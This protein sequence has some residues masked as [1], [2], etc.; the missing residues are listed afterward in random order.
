MKKTKKAFEEYMN[1]NS[2]PQGDKHWII[3]GVIRMG[4]MWQKK[5]GTAIRRYASPLFNEMF[6]K[7]KNETT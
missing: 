6:N 5:Y 2:P 1:E 3:G 7:W 4:H